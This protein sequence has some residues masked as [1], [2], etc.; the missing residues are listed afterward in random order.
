MPPYRPGLVNHDLCDGPG[1]QSPVP[2][3]SSP[4]VADSR[5][6]IAVL[7]LESMPGLRYLELVQEPLLP[8]HHPRESWCPHLLYLNL[9]LQCET[10]QS[11]KNVLKLDVVAH[12]CDLNDFG[13]WGKKIQ[14]HT[15]KQGQ[16]E[17][18]TGPLPQN[19]NHKKC[20]LWSSEVQCSNDGFVIK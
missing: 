11:D 5:F 16:N 14:L 6:C 15:E 19:K 2:V 9:G 17:Q 12:D 18:Y 3:L 8:S 13:S 7:A 4:F 1:H 10:S 20:W